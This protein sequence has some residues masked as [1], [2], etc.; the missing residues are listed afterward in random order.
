M[1]MFDRWNERNQKSFN[2]PVEK[3]SP[4]YVYNFSFD[5]LILVDVNKLVNNN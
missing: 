1:L 5:F 2:N 4:A 3:R